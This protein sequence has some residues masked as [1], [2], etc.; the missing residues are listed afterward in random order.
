MQQVA[1]LS[2]T[3]LVTRPR[4]GDQLSNAV[5]INRSRIPI[6]VF[7]SLLNGLLDAGLRHAEILQSKR[8]AKLHG[9]IV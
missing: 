4:T 8:R 9:E 3:R 2:N 1:A 7:D 6:G 5:T